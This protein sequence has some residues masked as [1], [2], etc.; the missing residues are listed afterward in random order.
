[1][2]RQVGGVVAGLLEVVAFDVVYSR[3]SASVSGQERRRRRDRGPGAPAGRLRPGV[4]R[5]LASRGVGVVTE[6][7]GHLP[8][9]SDQGWLRHWPG[10][11]STS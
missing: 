5:S 8:A 7:Q 2:R 3:H 9:H 6:D 4:A 10:E 1:M 11:A